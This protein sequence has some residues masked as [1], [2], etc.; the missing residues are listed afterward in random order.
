MGTLPTVIRVGPCSLSIT[1][2]NS[3]VAEKDCVKKKKME[4]RDVESS[5]ELNS[6]KDINN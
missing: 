4:F 2:D 1:V 5:T 3:V 6:G